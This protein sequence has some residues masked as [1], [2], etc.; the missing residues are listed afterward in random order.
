MIP[1]S[2]PFLPNR[3]KLDAYIDGIYQRAYLTNGGPLVHELTAR[4]RDYLGV[5]H[6]LLVANG[7]LALQ[8]AYAVLGVKAT[9]SQAI[10]TPFSFAATS[11]SL[12]WEGIEPRFA[13]ID[14]ASFCIS[15][16]AIAAAMQP[17]V[18][19][20][21]PV[22]V[23]GNACDV[24]AIEQLARQHNVKTIYD[25]AHAF[26]VK[27][28]GKSLLNYG[29]ATTLSLHA[30][31]L[32]H[33]VEGGGIIFQRAEDLALANQ[34]INFGY[35]RPGELHNVGINAKMS[36]FHAAMGLAVLDEIADIM[37][38]RAEICQFYTSSLKNAVQLPQRHPL[39]TEN[40]AYFPVLLQDETQL[41]RVKA[42]FEQADIQAR[43]YFYPS[44]DTLRYSNHAQYCP[45]SRNI[46]S[47][48]LC[49]PL[50]P[51]LAKSAQKQIVSLLLDAL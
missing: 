11:N 45:V 29:D 34:Y 24:V 47:R 12:S 32:F 43:R 22:H 42:K 16:T 36:E 44:L 1:V 2:K 10:T 27:L 5:E 39:A 46:A 48:A 50:F 35:R 51:G 23:Y 17:Q 13:D 31:K 18:R 33:S 25:G 15:P 38:Q 4:L 49:L 9:G 28:D 8:L 20:I 7:T 6:L 41:L 37:Q 19:A 26:G 30:T 40:H 21:V 3:K 14:D